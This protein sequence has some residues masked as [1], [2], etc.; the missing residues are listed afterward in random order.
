M[1]PVVG[2]GV[3]D[4]LGL[5]VGLG[6]GETGM[7]TVGAMVE[8]ISAVGLAGSTL[9]SSVGVAVAVEAVGVFSADSAGIVD[10]EVEVAVGAVVAVSAK[11]CDVVAGEGGVDVLPA[12]PQDAKTGLRRT[13]AKR[14]NV[15]AAVIID[16]Q[17]EPQVLL[18]PGY[19][20]RKYILDHVYYQFG[21]PQRAHSHFDSIADTYSEKKTTIPR[22]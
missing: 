5:A 17:L 20:T 10:S 3:G 22:C 6:V 21:S 11:V 14:A 7:L 9:A 2:V 15:L 1:I 8:A 16:L 13:R 4:G 12:P 19:E 18:V